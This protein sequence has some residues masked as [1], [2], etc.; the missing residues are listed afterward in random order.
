MKLVLFLV[1]FAVAALAQESSVGYSIVPNPFFSDPG[2]K[3][4]QEHLENITVYDLSYKSFDGTLLDGFL[5]EPN[6]SNTNYPVIIYNRGGNGSYGK[7]TEQYIMMFLSKIAARGYIILGSQLRD[8]EDEFGGKD[9]S[10][11]MQLFKIIDSRKTADTSK[12]AQIGWSRGGITNFLILKKTARIK[13]IVNIAGPAE[14][15]K[16]REKMFEV[17]RKRVPGYQ[18][19]S[20]AALHRISPINQIDSIKN[21]KAGFLF[22]HGGNDVRVDVQ[23]SR[24]LST[25]CQLT[26]FKSELVVYQEG[27]HSL[28]INFPEMVEKILQWLWQEL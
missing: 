7:V 3:K 10:D 15:M 24:D 16:S 11:V 13:A 5:I 17:Y 23:N 21:R 6:D 27:D 2:R 26:G 8:E 22:L 18:K 20:I 19:D 9:I 4:V 28:R 25:R 12:I 1:F 14:L